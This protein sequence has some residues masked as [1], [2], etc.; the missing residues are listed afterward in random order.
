MHLRDDRFHDRVPSES[1]IPTA[2]KRFEQLPASISTESPSDTRYAPQWDHLAM[3]RK[4]KWEHEL[5]A[6][7][8]EALLAVDLYNRPGEDRRL[9]A[10]IVHMHL[11]WLYLIHAHFEKT[12]VDYWYRD[13]D[14]KRQKGQDGQALTWEL[15]RCL[16]KLFKDNDPI[17]QNVAF[18]MGIRDKIEH[19]FENALSPMIAGKC[20]AYVLNYEETLVHRF[21]KRHGLAHQLRFP[22][23]LSTLTEDAV[24]VL[25]QTYQRLPKRLTRYVEA[26][27]QGLPDEVRDDPRYEFRITLLPQTGPASKSDV[28]MRFVRWDDLTEEQRAKLNR[29]QTIIREKRIPVAAKD[30]LKPSAVARRVEQ[31][32]G[33]HFNVSSDHA[34]AW[35]YYEVRPAWGDEHPERTK[36]DFCVYD[37]PHGD[38]VYTEAWVKFLVKELRKRARFSE[39]VGHDPV[40]L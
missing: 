19:R 1:T 5:A 32:L 39:V 7:K 26:F 25:K 11:A 33:V 18:F 4:R 23:F 13:S 20:Q 2:T 21:G 10:F 37:E 6:S 15:R 40:P 22:I 30:F 27:D 28:A 17:R 3:P 34:K 36:S 9:E 12:G 35:R 29:M 31:E 16:K 8:Q 14:G 38:W 24:S